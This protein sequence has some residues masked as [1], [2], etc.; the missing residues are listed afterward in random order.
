MPKLENRVDAL[1]KVLIERRHFLREIVQRAATA[2]IVRGKGSGAYDFRERG[3]RIGGVFQR[4]DPF[5][6]RKVRDH[7]IDDRVA[8]RFF[9][10]EMMVESSFGD[11]GVLDNGIDVGALEAIAVD[12][13]K[14]GPQEALSSAN[15]IARPDAAN[16]S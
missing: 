11:T 16:R 1:T 8:Q 14:G 3:D 10:G 13:M 9:P 4:S 5:F 12:V 6:E 15:R 7:L 2:K